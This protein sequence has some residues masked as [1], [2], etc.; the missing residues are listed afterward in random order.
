M[1]LKLYQSFSFLLF[2]LIPIEKVSNSNF[3]TKY[4]F[5]M[6]QNEEFLLCFPNVF[7]VFNI[8]VYMQEGDLQGPYTCR[9]QDGYGCQGTVYGSWEL[10]Q[11]IG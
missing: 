5:A 9:A 10:R 7:Q 1:E 4:S 6:S 3:S 11:C 8:C 2:L